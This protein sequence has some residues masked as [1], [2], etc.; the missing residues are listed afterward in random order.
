MCKQAVASTY[1]MCKQDTASTY[2]M[3]KQATPSTYTMCKQGLPKVNSKVTCSP[4]LRTQSPASHSSSP[5][6]QP[7]QWY[8]ITIRSHL[9]M[10]C[11]DQTN[12]YLWTFNCAT[13]CSHVPWRP[14]WSIITWCTQRHAAHD[15]NHHNHRSSAIHL[16]RVH[17]LR[18]LLPRANWK[19]MSWKTPIDFAPLCVFKCVNLICWEKMLTEGMEHSR[20]LQYAS[21]IALL[22]LLS[23]IGKS[24]LM[25]PF[26]HQNGNLLFW[27]PLLRFPFE[28]PF[29]TPLDPHHCPHLN[30]HPGHQTYSNWWQLE[31]ERY[32][33]RT[34]TW[35]HGEENISGWNSL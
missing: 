31:T 16:L 35:T 4:L 23:V 12:Q 27:L 5:Q 8:S 29:E 19:S 20:L 11:H 10:D 32:L 1:T 25:H 33:P 3:C 13:C 34:V 9:D 26:N 18:I 15:N 7:Y 17:L 22:C 14:C 30:L 6:S 28:E 21:S 24:V 2:T